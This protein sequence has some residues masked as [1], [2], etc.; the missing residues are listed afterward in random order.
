MDFFVCAVVRDYCRALFEGAVDEPRDGDVSCLFEVGKIIINVRLHSAIRHDVVEAD[1]LQRAPMSR[2][3]RP[4][5][6]IEV[7]NHSY[8]GA[9]LI[10]R[11]C[12]CCKGLDTAL[13]TGFPVLDGLV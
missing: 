1:V 8:V 5:R 6:Q 7:A 10:A 4:A 12:R 9:T 13:Q 2:I 11:D 3:E